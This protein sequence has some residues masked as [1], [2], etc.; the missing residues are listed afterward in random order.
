M[1]T[2]HHISLSVSNINNSLKFYEKLGFTEVLRWKA[3]DDSIEISH[4]KM[5]DIYLE[6]FCFKDFEEAPL[7]SLKLDTDLPRIGMKHFGVKVQSI[8]E[9]RQ[10]VLDNNLAKEITI[11]KG[12]TKIDYFF[13]QDPDGIF[14]EFVQDDRGI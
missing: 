1:F 8:E 7:T 5:G 14:I 11:K 6:L 9:A 3:D 10:W 4:L 13:I 2:I 12:K